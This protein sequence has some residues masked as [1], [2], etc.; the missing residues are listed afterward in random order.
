MDQRAADSW[1]T[2]EQLTPQNI[3]ILCGASL[4]RGAV[5]V[6]LKMLSMLLV[7]LRVIENRVL[8]TRRLNQLCRVWLGLAGLAIGCVATPVPDPPTFDPPAADQVIVGD[9]GTSSALPTLRLLPGAIPEGTLL[10]IVNLDSE[11]AA[12]ELA[13]GES[14]AFP[15]ALGDHVRLQIRDLESSERS[16]VSDGVIAPV[17]EPLQPLE[18]LLACVEVDAELEMTSANAVLAIHNGCTDPVSFG[19]HLRTASDNFV[20][21]SSNLRME[22]A[23]DERADVSI[24]FVQNSAD[25]LEQ[26]VLIDAV[27]G[28]I[29]DRFAT[30]VYSPD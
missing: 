13:P 5:K 18:H 22:L 29:E 30:T 10:R 11:D 26:L 15:S 8:K 3:M 28:E 9:E 2:V 23:P 12:L 7:W 24:A 25:E 21:D 17:D 27:A 4:A 16:P 6:L 1:N 19:V 14:A 20:V